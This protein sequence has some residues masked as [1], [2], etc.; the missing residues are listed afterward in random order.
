MTI[1]D[2]IPKNVAFSKGSLGQKMLLYNK[3]IQERQDY[4]HEGY[5]QSAAQQYWNNIMIKLRILY[6][7]KFGITL[8][9]SMNE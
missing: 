9:H 8:L 6:L 2:C 4:C 7:Y 3:G 5:E 1:Y